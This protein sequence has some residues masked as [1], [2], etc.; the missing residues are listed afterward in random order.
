MI[1]TLIASSA[2][3]CILLQAGVPAHR[4]GARQAPAEGD[5]GV[6]RRRRAH[7]P[8][9]RRA[10]RGVPRAAEGGA[11]AGRR[12]RRPRAQGRRGRTSARPS[13]RA[14]DARGAAR[15]DAPRHRGRDAARDPGDPQRGRRPHGAGDR[16]GH[17]QVA[18]RR[19]PA[20]ARRGGARRARL[21]RAAPAEDR[22]SARWRRSPRSTPRSLFEVAKE[23][24]KLDVVREQL[25]QFADALDG[26][27]R[28]AGVLL[29]ALLLHR[30]EEGRAATRCSR[31]PTRRS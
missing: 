18:R 10:A 14:G 5:R 9:G 4:R 20:P 15:A 31:A 8:G 26:R 6:D 27:P 12:H 29:L 2:S 23:Q 28:A 7:A 21:L 30:G 3:R 1:W 25:G 16:E 13:R 11:R 24:D 17:A 19:R 22:R